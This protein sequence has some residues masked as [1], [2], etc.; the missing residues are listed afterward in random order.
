MLLQ[1]AMAM[2]VLIYRICV[3]RSDHD[4][5]KFLINF[6]MRI[7]NSNVFLPKTWISY[8]SSL[9]KYLPSIFMANV[10]WHFV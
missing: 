3:G 2:L 4:F 9:L 10:L 5:V 6:F 7:R 1:I 8:S